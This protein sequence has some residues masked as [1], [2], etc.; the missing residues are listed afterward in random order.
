MWRAIIFGCVLTLASATAGERSPGNDLNNDGGP[1]DRY[2]WRQEQQER[3]WPRYAPVWPQWGYA[4]PRYE[5]YYPAPQ[6]VPRY[7][8][9]ESYN[10]CM[11]D[12]ADRFYCERY[13]PYDRD[14]W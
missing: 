11:W 1:K 6:Y 3:W 14:E 4:P 5:P 2:Q 12:N 10:A 9:W 8:P 13:L 7:D